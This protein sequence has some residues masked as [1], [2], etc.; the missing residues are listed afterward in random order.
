MKARSKKMG[1]LPS[2]IFRHFGIALLFLLTQKQITGN[3]RIACEVL[4]RR[5]DPTRIIILKHPTSNQKKC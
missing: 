4:G 2:C 5:E 1:D 3:I